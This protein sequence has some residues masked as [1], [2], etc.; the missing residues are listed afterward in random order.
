MKLLADLLDGT[1]NDGDR[2]TLTA[3]FA[4]VLVTEGNPHDYIAL[5]DRFVDDTDTYFGTP[6]EEKYHNTGSVNSHKRTRSVNSSSLTSNTSSLRRKF[7]F[8]TL[9]RENSK[10]EQESK[11]HSVWRTLSKTNR[12]DASPHGSLSKA[13]LGRSQSIDEGKGLGSRPLSQD[14]SKHYHGFGEM[15]SMPA[16]GRTPSSHNLGLSTIGEHPSFIPTGPPRKKRRSSLSDLKSLDNTPQ[17]ERISP[18]RPRQPSPQRPSPQ[19]PPLVHSKTDVD[20]ELPTSPPPSTPS[21]SRLGNGRF[22]TPVQTS[23]RSRLP[24]SFRRELSPGPLRALTRP[25]VPRPKTSGGNVE[26]VRPKTSGRPSDEVTITTRPTSNI[27]SLAPRSSGFSLQT[28]APLTPM[29]SGLSERPGAG[30]IVKKPSPPAEKITR[31]R[32]HTQ[33]AAPTTP[34]HRK[35]RMQSPHKLRERLQNEQSSILAAQG[36]LQDELSKI[37][38]ELTSSTMTRSLARQGSKSNTIG[39][40]GSFSQH[41]DMDLAQRV[42]KMEGQLPKQAEEINARIDSIQ[43]DLTTSLSVSETKSK[44]L[45]ELYREANAENEALYARF[46]DELSRVMKA[47]RGGEGVEELKKKLK[48]SQEE[49]AKL[50]RDTNRLKR[51]NVGLRSQLRE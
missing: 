40:R 30:N 34:S 28:P 31:N 17:K 12:S 5:I 50:R 33:S 10:S 22:T 25:E 37:G 41:S 11:V 35:L 36:S 19:R 14:S 51:E 32:S 46:N 2:G 6:V 42:L 29:R 38:H 26:H 27:P 1:G 9:S 4:E 16:L 15:P 43:S 23:P 21:S 24:S 3:C 48:D 18:D 39:G 13:S 45:D 8:T 7:G 49:A 20:K 47:V 44:K